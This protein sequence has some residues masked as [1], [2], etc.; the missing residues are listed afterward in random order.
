MNGMGLYLSTLYIFRLAETE[1]GPL[2]RKERALYMLCDLP[3][4]RCGR[5]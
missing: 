3:V 4:L 5:Q 1:L 2:T